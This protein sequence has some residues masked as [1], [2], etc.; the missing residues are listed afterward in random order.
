VLPLR[1]RTQADHPRTVVNS[2]IMFPYSYNRRKNYAAGDRGTHAAFGAYKFIAGGELSPKLSS[3]QALVVQ[4]P[5][6]A[7]KYFH[8]SGKS[9]RYTLIETI[10]RKTYVAVIGGTSAVD[11]GRE[12]S[13][14]CERKGTLVS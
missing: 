2:T 4:N 1:P 7:T 8:N 10:F 9:Q 11:G 13:P 12:P 14:V 5:K 3:Q 6:Q